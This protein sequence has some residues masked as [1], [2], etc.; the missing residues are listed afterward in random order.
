MADRM[1]EVTIAEKRMETDRIAS[2][3]L[4]GQGELPTWSPGAHAASRFPN[5]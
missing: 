4:A 1:F 2:F 3:I 5:P